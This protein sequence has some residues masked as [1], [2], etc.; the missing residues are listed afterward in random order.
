MTSGSA[1]WSELGI[2]RSQRDDR[3][4]RFL[5]DA[6]ARQRFTRA[7]CRSPSA[8]GCAPENSPRTY[9]QS[10]RAI[11]I[12]DYLIAATAA[13]LGIDLATLN[14]RDFPMFSGLRPA[15]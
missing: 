11:G 12:A 3:A 8:S 5:F 1:T 7:R 14:V 15:F 9:R 6:R 10:H 2:V 13:E 4:R